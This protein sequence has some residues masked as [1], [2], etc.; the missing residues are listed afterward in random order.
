MPQRRPTRAVRALATLALAAVA[1]SLAATPARAAAVFVETNPSTVPVSERLAVRASCPD[2]LA[3][4]VV[5]S[6][7]FGTVTVNPEYGF[8]T[9]TVTVPADTPVGDHRVRLT[10]PGGASASSVLHVVARDRPSQGPATGFGGTA[11]NSGP[12]LIGAGLAAL[13][14]GVGLGVV[15]LRRRRAA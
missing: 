8:L 5:S 9:A 2:N 12:A 1:V 14:A 10:C 13:A 11:G 6:D 4:A 15:S 7:A 3:P